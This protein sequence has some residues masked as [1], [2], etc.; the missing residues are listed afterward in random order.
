LLLQVACGRHRAGEDVLDFHVDPHPPQLGDDV[1]AR[2][3]AVVGQE[4]KRDVVGAQRRHEP[5]R[6]RDHLRAAV[7]NTIHVDQVSVFQVETPSV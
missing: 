6:A 3:L 5:I 1:E 7:E 2:P 4:T